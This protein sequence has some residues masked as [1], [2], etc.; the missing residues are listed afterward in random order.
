MGARRALLET[1]AGVAGLLLL[2]IVPP[3]LSSFM[4]TLLTQA[5]IYGILA[6]SLD[7]ILGYTGLALATSIAAIVLMG[8]LKSD[9]QDGPNLG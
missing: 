6:M 9:W 7:I 8:L 2:V 5:L 4:L 1:L 3:A